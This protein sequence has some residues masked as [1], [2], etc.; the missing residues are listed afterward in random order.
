MIK[1]IELTE[2]EIITL[3]EKM[4]GDLEFLNDIRI[5]EGGLDE[6]DEND[7]KNLISIVKKLKEAGVKWK[8]IGE[9]MYSAMIDGQQVVR[10]KME[11]KK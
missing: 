6:G 2:S 4:M 3:I 7:R 8:K 10:M 11:G 5:E 1:L 9:W